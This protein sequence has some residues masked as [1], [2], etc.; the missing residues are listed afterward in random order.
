M[1]HFQLLMILIYREVKPSTVVG[2]LTEAIK[3]G[4]PL[5]VEK[6]NVTQR[7]HE[8]IIAAVKKIG[9]GICS[10]IIIYLNNPT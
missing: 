7:D 9:L 10:L 3:L 8:E 2:D 1:T 5:N 4:L 6:L